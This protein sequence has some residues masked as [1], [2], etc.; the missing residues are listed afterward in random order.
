[1][2]AGTVGV[3]VDDTASE[4]VHGQLGGVDDGV[5]D[6][7]GTQRC[8]GLGETVDA[9]ATEPF[10]QVIGGAEAEMAELVETFGAGVTPGAVG[11]E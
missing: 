8:G 10:P 6:K 9:D 5:T 3:D 2:E 7:V 11:D 4:G 1:M